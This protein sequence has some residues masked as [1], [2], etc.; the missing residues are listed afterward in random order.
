METS[1]DAKRIPLYQ[2]AYQTLKERIISG[3]YPDGTYLPSERELCEEFS[4][5]RIT[6]R[7]SLELLAEQGMIKKQAGKGTLVL[8]CCEEALNYDTAETK[9]I[10]FALCTDD[11]SRDRFSEPFQSGLFYYLERECSGLGYHLLYKT[12]TPS[13]HIQS[14]LQGIHI[15]Y[16]IFSSQVRPELLDEAY[17]LGIPALI[18]NNHDDRFTSV[19]I[20]NFSGARM[21]TQY[22]IDSGHKKIAV[23]TGPDTYTTS[24]QRLSGWKAAL[25]SGGLSPKQ[26]L[27][28]KGDWDFSSGYDAGKQIAQL[29]AVSRPD[30]VFAFNDDM[31]MGIMKALLESNIS[32][33]SDISLVGFDD[34][35]A[36]VQV[37]PALTTVH[38]DLHAIATA[39]IQQL[40]YTFRQKGKVP[41]LSIT[42]PV[43]IIIRDSSY[44]R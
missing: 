35:P 32:V 24:M 30:A 41:P 20:D 27:V 25:K 21:I 43:S 26:M 9:Y 6:L 31:A 11:Q 14:M 7:K 44:R 22:L 40:F 4:L 33:P 38:V 36:C 13:D 10:A 5:N 18:V 39:I 28:I 37:S 19:Q 3:A 17:T 42:V 34:V 16:I 23:L 8:P 29:P 1:P 2:Q 12:V 15:S